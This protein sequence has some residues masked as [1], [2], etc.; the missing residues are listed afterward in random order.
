MKIIKLLSSIIFLLSIG[1]NYCNA[2]QNAD[3]IYTYLN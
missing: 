3:E 1:L 2:D